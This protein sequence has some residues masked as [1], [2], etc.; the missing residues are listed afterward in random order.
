[1]S[2]PFDSSPSDSSPTDEDG[3][4]Q[5]TTRE[6]PVVPASAAT[7]PA[8]PPSAVPA[9][10]AAPLPPHP[11]ALPPAPLA[12]PEQPAEPPRTAPAPAGPQPTGPVDFV[13]G[14]PAMGAP[15]PPP[16]VPEP[17]GATAAGAPVPTGTEGRTWPDTLDADAPPKKS[18]ARVPQDRGTLLG[19][20][21][22]VLGVVLLELG[23]ALDFGGRSLWSLV[24]LWAA[25]AT[26]AA[27]LALVAFVPVPA[28]RGAEPGSGGTAS[29][30][31]GITWRIAVGGLVGLAVF[32]L[33][34]VLPHADTNRGFVL[35]AA[36]GAL[37]AGLWVGP[38][39]SR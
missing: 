25:F 30:T 4:A 28:S 13:P 3:T 16:P 6:I 10:G 11:G 20:G 36:L 22:A 34:V 19:A 27:L 26:V 23:L 31:T 2:S 1:M 9:A 15:V 21:L 33:L 17:T 24:P 38:A 12:P 18:R 32:W 14:P 37:G 8:S 5:P 7:P 35:T 39:R 29:A